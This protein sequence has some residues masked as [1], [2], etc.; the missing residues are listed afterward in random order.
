MILATLG[1]L[2]RDR[3]SRLRRNGASARL[4]FAGRV[5]DHCCMAVDWTHVE[6]GTEEHPCLFDFYVTGDAREALMRILEKPAKDPARREMLEL[7]LSELVRAYSVYKIGK[8]QRGF[9]L[10]A[11]GGHRGMREAG[12]LAVE[13]MLERGI[14]PADVIWRLGQPGGLSWLAR[15]LEVVPWPILCSIKII[16]MTER[17]NAKPP[18]GGKPAAPVTHS[19][20]KP[21]ERASDDLRSL[22]VARFGKAAVDA[23][24]TDD[25]ELFIKIE[26]R[27]RELKRNPRLYL[28]AASKEM[29]QWYMQEH[30]K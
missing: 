10:G 14:G 16:D 24:A 18:K 3:A 27:A 4:D 23:I 25:G 28:P 12:L 8:G 26:A 17:R 20:S 7:A 1:S 5:C 11:T 13:A 30:V 6:K 21:H 19:Y 15:P 22:L 29:V 9:Y 2:I